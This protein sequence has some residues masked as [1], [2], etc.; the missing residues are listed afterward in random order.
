MYSLADL[1]TQFSL[2]NTQ[3][4]Q[5]LQIHQALESYSEDLCDLID[6]NPPEAQC[7]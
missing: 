2:S 3:F 1:Q 5:Y 7:C 4:Y 6:F